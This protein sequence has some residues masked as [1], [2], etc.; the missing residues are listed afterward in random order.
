MIKL[1]SLKLWKIEVRIRKNLCCKRRL[2]FILDIPIV[3]YG[4]YGIRKR[5]IYHSNKNIYF[6]GFLFSLAKTNI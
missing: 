2:W 4:C 1:L 5:G 6:M 3:E